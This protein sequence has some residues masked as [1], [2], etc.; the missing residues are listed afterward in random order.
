L[1]AIVALTIA[2]TGLTIGV[3]RHSLGIIG[4]VSIAAALGITV[5]AQPVWYIRF[6]Q[7]VLFGLLVVVFVKYK[8]EYVGA[9]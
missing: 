3:P 6:I 9:K 2:L 5:F 8:N 7:A 1:I 4:L